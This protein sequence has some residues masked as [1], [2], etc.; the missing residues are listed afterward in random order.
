MSASSY[1]IVP[2]G[3]RYPPDQ[4]PQLPMLLLRAEAVLATSN[5]DSV[6]RQIQDASG[7]GYH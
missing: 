1:R 4:T 6:L 7:S 2:K 5:L 3:F